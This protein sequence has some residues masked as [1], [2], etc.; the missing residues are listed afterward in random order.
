MAHGGSDGQVLLTDSYSRRDGAAG[1][2]MTLQSAYLNGRSLDPRLP[3]LMKTW[4]KLRLFVLPR[5]NW[6]FTV[7]WRTDNDK[8]KDAVTVNQ[9]QYDTH[10][11][12]NVEGDGSGDFR[13]TL[14][15]DAR[16]H[17]REEMAVLEVALD[18]RGYAL[19][20]TIEQSGA[21][22]DLVIQ[23]FEVEFQPDGYEEE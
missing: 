12:G 6:D 1:Y 22:E 18:S 3:G 4:K 17:T 16:L 10:V 8:A 5:G 13:L 11:L 14:D 2:T 7:Q 15:P 21:G 20:F 9:N 23:G 19:R